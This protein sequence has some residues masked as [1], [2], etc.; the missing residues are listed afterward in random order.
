ML[1]ISPAFL[2]PAAATSDFRRPKVSGA[3]ASA[4]PAGGAVDDSPPPPDGDGG[5]PGIFGACGS[6][7]AWLWR[8]MLFFEALNDG[9]TARMEMS[10]SEKI[11]GI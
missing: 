1:S 4:A 11:D 7:M 6:A 5:I 3:A 10:C 8:W 2:S 9:W